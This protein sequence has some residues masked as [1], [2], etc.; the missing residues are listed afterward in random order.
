MLAAITRALEHPRED[1]TPRNFSLD[2]GGRERVSCFSI[3]S[4][5]QCRFVD[6]AWRMFKLAARY[7]VKWAGPL[8][9]TFGK[10]YC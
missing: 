9:T 10:A 1:N 5:V 3:K 6:N 4:E 7:S 2:D 8:Q